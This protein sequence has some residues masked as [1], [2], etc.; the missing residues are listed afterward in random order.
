MHHASSYV[1]VDVN[2][3]LGDANQITDMAHIS[4]KYNTC[5]GHQV[6]KIKKTMVVTHRHSTKLEGVPV[7]QRPTR[8]DMVA[9]VSDFSRK[10]TSSV[11]KYNLF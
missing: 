3:S 9:E 8:S 2:H 7:G 10:Y 5:S 6:T 1:I 11:P 4:C